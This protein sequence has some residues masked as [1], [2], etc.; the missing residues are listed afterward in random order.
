MIGIARLSCNITE[1]KLPLKQGHVQFPYAYRQVP[2][3]TLIMATAM[4]YT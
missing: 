1:I 3:Y 4:K 2:L